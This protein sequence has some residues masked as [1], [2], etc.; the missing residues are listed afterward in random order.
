MIAMNT[1]F[2][3]KFSHMTREFSVLHSEHELRQTGKISRLIRQ[4]M[5]GV[6]RIQGFVF[7]YY[8]AFRSYCLIHLIS[9]TVI[10]FTWQT[11]NLPL[12][13]S[14]GDVRI[15]SAYPI[16]DPTP[17]RHRYLPA[18]D[19]P[20]AGILNISPV[21]ITCP[22]FVHSQ[23]TPVGSGRTMHCKRTSSPNEQYGG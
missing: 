8:S 9:Y 21:P 6:Q 15:S 14:V 18:S 11:F 1:T 5:C 19:S 2:Y 13:S 7:I 20:K 4:Y 23:F 10:D 22:S 17:A 16:T 12:V 3:R